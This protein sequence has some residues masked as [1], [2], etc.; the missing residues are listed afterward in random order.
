MNPLSNQNSQSRMFSE[1][2]EKKIFEQAK[3]YAFDY[4]DQSADRNIIPSE[5]AIENLHVFV[6]ELPQ[7]GTEASDVLSLLHQYG[8][9]ATVNQIGGRYYGFVN[10]GAVPVS[11]AS[12]WLAD[13]W[14]QNAALEVM[15]PLVSQLETVVEKWISE[16]LNFPTHTAAGF[17]SGTTT[18]VFCGLIAARYRIF[19]RQGWDL[20]AKG[21]Y[22][23]PRIRIV[24]GKQMHSSVL[25]SIISLGLGKDNI[26]WVDVDEEGR[27]LPDQIPQLDSHTILLL[28]AGEVNS[29]AF[30]PFIEIC[31]K[32]REAGAWIHVDGAFGLWAGA[33]DR[34]HA[35]TQGMELAHSWSVDGHKTLNTP[36]DCGIVLCEDRDA[37]TSAL[38]TSA[39]Y[40][41]YGQKRDGMLYTPAMSRRARI[42]ELWSVIKYLG[43]DGIEEMII[44]LHERA[45]QFGQELK[46][47]GFELL[48]EVA[49]NQVLIACE[50]EELTE[51]TLAHIKELRECWCGG[52][53]W[54]GRKVI[55]I[56]VCSWATTA[57]DVSRSVR[58]F[59]KGRDLARA[60]SALGI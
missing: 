48:N 31:Q 26:E 7:S 14:D 10:G 16:L 51:S 23:A 12:K 3:S 18:A 34:F 45:L 8:S 52:S 1:L 20:R 11:L 57:E 25:R 55:R 40:L 43:K 28:Q 39:A 29:G 46:A 59:V 5:E 53:N 9:P 37:L 49:F 42:I 54:F 2:Q 21:M 38:Q 33:V 30:D 36:Y 35:L 50:T 27:I 47:A 32:A 17:V 44:N 15:S 41:P 22:G 19:E 4:V 6:E 58:S 56:S 13:F 60:Q 24:A